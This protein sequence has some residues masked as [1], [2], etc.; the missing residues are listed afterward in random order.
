MP[1]P[2]RILVIDDSQV[3]LDRIKRAL[4]SA[5]HEVVVTT[6]IVGNARYLATCHL[7]IIDYH[8]PGLNGASVV[9]SLRAIASSTK[10]KCSLFLYTSDEKIERNFAA[11]GF[12][13]A[14]SRKGDEAALVQQV[15]S[16]FRTL[17][18]RGAIERRNNSKIPPDGM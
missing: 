16:L 5:G 1:E 14:F 13:G 2:K 12:D 8:M 6:Q 18:M 7:L 11:L 9:A 3:M 17:D 10:N 15:A 4:S